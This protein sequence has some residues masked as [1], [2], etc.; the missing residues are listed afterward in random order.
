MSTTAT[1]AQ[2]TATQA[3]AA[4]AA[5]EAAFAATVPPPVIAANRALFSEMALASMAG[6]AIGGTVNPGRRE[7]I[8]ATTRACP[9]PSPRSPG[10][11]ITGIAAEISELAEL[12]GKL[13]VLRDSGILTDQEFNEQKRRLLGSTPAAI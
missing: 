5:Y 12:L 3:K 7:R 8:R 1:Q 13:G 11:P 2:Q 6:R 4:A 10:G 9:A